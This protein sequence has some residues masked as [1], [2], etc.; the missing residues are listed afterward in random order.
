MIRGAVLACTAILIGV[1]LTNISPPSRLRVAAAAAPVR[2]TTVTACDASNPVTFLS[3]LRML[4]GYDPDPNHPGKT[5][6][7]GTPGV[8][9]PYCTS[10]T[11]AYNLATPSFQN[12]LDS[13][14]NTFIDTDTCGDG[15]DC[16]WGFDDVYTTG[17]GNTYVALYS[18]F[19]N[20]NAVPTYSAF[21]PLVVNDLMQGLGSP[22]SLQAYPDSQELALI[23]ALA[24][25]VGHVKWFQDA[26]DQINKTANLCLDPVTRSYTM[27]AGTSRFPGITWNKNVGSGKWRYFGKETDG[28]QIYGGVDKEQLRKDLSR[29]DRIAVNS[30]LQTIYNGSWASIFWSLQTKIT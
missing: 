25:E 1:C 28:N 17:K 23:A 13:L 6:P 5:L 24:H 14:T 7:V 18:S 27:F 19:W 10:L 29:N 16:A 9:E 12:A 22:V 4:S 21:V 15:I 3:R 26:V 20:G 2:M 30:D 11:N 8:G